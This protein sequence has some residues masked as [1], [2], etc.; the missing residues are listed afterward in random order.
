MVDRKA[1]NRV[2]AAPCRRGVARMPDVRALLRERAERAGESPSVASDPG[3]GPSAV[4]CRRCGWAGEYDESDRGACP[5]CR[6]FV[7]GNERALKHGLR[8]LQ[9]GGGSPLDES[10]RRE[11]VAAITSDLGGDLSTIAAGLVRDLAAATQLRDACYA[12]LAA[13][14]PFT[15]AGKRRP[16]VDL[17][18]AVSSRVERLSALLGLSRKSRPVPTV[19]EWIEQ[20]TGASGASSEPPSAAPSAATEEPAS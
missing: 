10:R 9:T 8:R 19:A 13:V 12:H 7:T 17:Y 16:A 2:A 14:G 6:S 5:E 3:G 18:L 11:I 15:A 20:Q 1:R 4:S